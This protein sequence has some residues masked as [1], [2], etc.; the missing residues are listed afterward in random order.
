MLAAS[1]AL[2]INC[3]YYYATFPSNLIRIYTCEGNVTTDCNTEITDV[4]GTH[5]SEKKNSDVKVFYLKYY[6]ATNLR[7]YKLPSNLSTYFPKLRGI[8]WM[9]SKLDNIKATDLKPFP[10]L[11]Y[12]D[13]SHNYLRQLDG[14]LFKY[15]PQLNLLVMNDNSIKTI[16]KGLFTGVTALRGA[17]FFENP[18]VGKGE[19]L[20]TNISKKYTVAV[21]QAELERLCP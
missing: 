9:Q 6:G 20:Q 16:G 17:N 5:E 12:L 21:L 14:D 11:V 10:N 7:I 15:T 2:T 18:C 13:L 3:Q 19:K 1:N 8:S 4:T